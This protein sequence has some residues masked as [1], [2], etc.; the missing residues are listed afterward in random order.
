LALELPVLAYFGAETNNHSAFGN[1]RSQWAC[2]DIKPQQ[3]HSPSEIRNFRFPAPFKNLSRRIE[4]LCGERR[5]IMETN[6]WTTEE[7][8]ILFTDLHEYSIVSRELGSE[9]TRAFL[10]EFYESAGDIIVAYQG[11]I[12]KYMGDAILCIFPA[13]SEIEAVRCA[14]QMRMAYEELVQRWNIT[15]DTELEVGIDSGDVGVGMIGHASLR[16]KDVFSEH[17]NRAGVIGHHRGIAITDDVHK[18]VSAHVKTAPLP[19]VTL[20]W[21]NEPLKMWEVLEK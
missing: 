9:N 20:K 2:C 21:Q 3:A 7:R 10:Q 11:E 1:T 6:T 8:V 12:I 13:D 4:T 15:H 14:Q 5:I 19:D 16:T 17:V 18:A